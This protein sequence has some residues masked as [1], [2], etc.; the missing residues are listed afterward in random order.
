MNKIVANFQQHEKG[1]GERPTIAEPKT[2]WWAKNKGMFHSELKPFMPKDAASAF[3]PGVAGVNGNVEFALRPQNKV[4]TFV[5]QGNVPSR[6]GDTSRVSRV[7][8]NANTFATG[9]KNNQST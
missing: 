5:A 6:V 8:Q 2:A 9:D 3:V 7:R 4:V 1:N